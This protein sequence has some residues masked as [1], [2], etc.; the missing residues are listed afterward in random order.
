MNH[1]YETNQNA[2]VRHQQLMKAAANVRRVKNLSSNRSQLDLIDKLQKLLTFQVASKV[3]TS[4][5][6][7]VK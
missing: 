3:E 6:L 2:K 4:D 7:A 1:P 5:D